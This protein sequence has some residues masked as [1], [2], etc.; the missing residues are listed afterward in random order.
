MQY[1]RLHHDT[2]VV[3]LWHNVHALSHCTDGPWRTA[4]VAF[5]S[6]EPDCGHRAGGAQVPGHSL[7]PGRQKDI[8]HCPPIVQADRIQFHFR[9]HAQHLALVVVTSRSSSSLACQRP[10]MW[11]CYVTLAVPIQAHQAWYL[12]R[13]LQIN[14]CKTTAL[15][16]QCWC[17][18]HFG[19]SAEGTCSL[20]RR[21]EC[22]QGAVA[23]YS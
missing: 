3:L 20:A 14:L 13:S 22:R 9:K 15:L 11:R 12:R 19:C 18:Q 2:R 8:L 4:E 21:L 7:R 17:S 6:R 10:S 23:Q 1:S 16:N 5:A